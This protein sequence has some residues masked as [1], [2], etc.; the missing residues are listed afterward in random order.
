MLHMRVFN[1]KFKLQAVINQ[2]QIEV[3]LIVKSELKRNQWYNCH[4]VK[5]T[6]TEASNYMGILTVL[7]VGFN[8]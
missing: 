1:N 2:A 6:L 7:H 4:L 3:S 8:Y 5:S